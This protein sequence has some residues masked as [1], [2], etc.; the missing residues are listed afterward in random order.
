MKNN[1][2][3]HKP[4]M[5]VAHRLEYILL[6]SFYFMWCNHKLQGM[7]IIVFFE[8]IPLVLYVLISYEDG[9]SPWCIQFEITA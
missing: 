8:V 2:H 9:K 1:V 5:F 3:E 7:L 4:I 6:V